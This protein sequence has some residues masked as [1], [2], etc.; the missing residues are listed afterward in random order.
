MFGRDKT[1]AAQVDTLIGAAA[2]IQGDLNFEGGLHLDGGVAGNVRAPDGGASMLSVSEQGCI[3]GS[4]RV[5]HVIL[6]G[7]VKGDIYAASRI[8]LGAK[9]RVEGNVLYGVIEMALGAEIRGK[10][11]PAST[12]AAQVAVGNAS[13]FDQAAH[14]T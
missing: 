7:T 8:V 13:A 14:E 5:P 11:V 3:E 6:N 1:A 10:L 9:S 4:V 12:I 2:R